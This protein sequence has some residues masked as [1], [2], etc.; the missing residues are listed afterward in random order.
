MN[1]E[2]TVT[3]I[4]YNADTAAIEVFGTACTGGWLRIDGIRTL[5]RPKWVRRPLT[6]RG[7][8]FKLPVK[9]I[10]ITVGATLGKTKKYLLSIDKSLH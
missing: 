10:T 9:E 6:V 5:I 8:K 7:R 2:I 1:E 3:S 4:R